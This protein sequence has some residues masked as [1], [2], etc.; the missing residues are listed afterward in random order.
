[1]RKPIQ[2]NSYSPS[3][4]AECNLEK[5]ADGKS[6]CKGWPNIWFV[7]KQAESVCEQSYKIMGD[8]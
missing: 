1:M 2:Q 5:T 3:V 7:R 4:I 8:I 6:Q